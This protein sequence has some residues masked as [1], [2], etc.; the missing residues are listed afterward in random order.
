[1][2]LLVGKY[3]NFDRAALGLRLSLSIYQQ[4]EGQ[5]GAE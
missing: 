4:E 3:S 2:L 1:L 5:K